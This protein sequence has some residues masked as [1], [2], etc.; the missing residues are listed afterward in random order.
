VIIGTQTRTRGRS[1]R[2]TRLARLSSPHGALCVAACG[3]QVSER[4]L[5]PPQA[6]AEPRSSKCLFYPTVIDPADPPIRP[7]RHV[8]SSIASIR[9]RLARALVRPLF[10]CPCCQRKI[11]R[12]NL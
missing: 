3:F 9:I 10:R 4:S 11:R 5:I 7:E 1:L 8:V 2:G 12:R 6:P